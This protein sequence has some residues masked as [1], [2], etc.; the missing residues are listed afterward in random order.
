M[1][2]KNKLFQSVRIN[3]KKYILIAV[4]LL[5][6]FYFIFS[7]YGLIKRFSLEMDLK[8]KNKELETCKTTKDSLNKIIYKLQTD[9]LEIERIA[10]EKYGMTKDNEEV[11]YIE[12]K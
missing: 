9:S 8:S 3:K 11:Y 10:R 2:F 12:T 7:D 4:V 6:T 5:F 1:D